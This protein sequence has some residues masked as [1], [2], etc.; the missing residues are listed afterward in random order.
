[1]KILLTNDDGYHAR[2]FLHLLNLLVEE[3]HEVRVVAPA[4]EQSGVS[5][6]ITIHSPLRVERFVYTMELLEGFGL[7]NGN[8]KLKEV[9]AWKVHGTPADCG[10]FA[11]LGLFGGLKPILQPWEPDVLLS[12]INRGNNAGYNV[13]Y[14][15]TV[16]GAMEGSIQGIPS[17]AVS[18]NHPSDYPK[19][20]EAW[21]Y[22]LAAELFL[23]LIPRLL[24]VSKKIDKT[25]FWNVNIPNVHDREEVKGTKLCKQGGWTFT[26][27][28][29]EIK[30]EGTDDITYTRRGAIV[31]D[32]HFN[33]N[34]YDTVAVHEGYITVTPLSHF[35]DRLSSQEKITIEKEFK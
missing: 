5:H 11:L 19:G 13:I 31:P 16:A 15:G 32:V 35:L 34:D 1:M 29:D 24:D 26:E 3:G 25:T 10:Q 4:F 2:G 17:I 7:K 21:P 6:C 20:T 14:S 28:F 18:L 30:R 9:P 33:T 22:R 27:Y 12:G 23:P 8:E